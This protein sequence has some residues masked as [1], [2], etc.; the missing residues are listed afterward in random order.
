MP[1]GACVHFPIWLFMSDK[2]AKALLAKV[3]AGDEDSLI[4]IRSIPVLP[5]RYRYPVRCA[6]GFRF[7]K[8]DTKGYQP[9]LAEIR[10]Y[11]KSDPTLRNPDAIQ[12]AVDRYV[13]LLLK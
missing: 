6:R 8:I 7:D 10:A 5:L 11:E 4:A 3:A 13:S 12:N 9:I 2:A 1:E